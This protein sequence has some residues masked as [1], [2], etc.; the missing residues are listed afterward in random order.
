MIGRSGINAISRKLQEVELSLV[1]GLLF[2]FFWGGGLGF[3][4]RCC[5]PL[6]SEWCRIE[7][8]MMMVMMMMMMMTTTTTRTTMDYDYRDEDNDSNSNY[9][10]YY[11][12]TLKG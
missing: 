10:C 9:W 2:F 11:P 3:S 6:Y 12:Q 7:M 4:H 1:Y 5:F 8:I